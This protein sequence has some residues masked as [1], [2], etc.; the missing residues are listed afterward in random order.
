MDLRAAVTQGEG[1]ND[2]E[3]IERARNLLGKAYYALYNYTLAMEHHA[4]CNAAIEQGLVND[5]IF[6]LDVF[7]NLANDYLRLGDL[8]K[9]VLFYRRALETLEGIGRDS[10]SS[11][12]K[13]MEI[14]QQ[15]K[16]AGKLLWARDYA[17]H[18]LAIYDMRDEQKMVGLTHQRLGKAL[19][20]QN[21][22]D[23]AEREY[24]QAIAIETELHD[25]VAASICHTSLAELLLKR[26]KPDEAQKEAKK[27][28]DFARSSQDAQ[29]QGQ[30]LIALAQIHHHRQIFAEADKLFQQALEMLDKAEAHEVAA[31]AYFRYA[32][33]LEERGE[34]QASLD[35]IKKACAHQGSGK[36]GEME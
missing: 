35:A 27:A 32:N 30:A 16:T 14:A 12:Q 17:M 28:Q 20:R 25:E 19:E 29:T 9:S 36:R 15:Y 34:V 13:F 3:Y 7:S 5:P 23:Q 10:K 8:E 24:R 4:R 2:I 33:V 22:L 6:S 18:S 11:A 31:T 1:M 21:D 26:G